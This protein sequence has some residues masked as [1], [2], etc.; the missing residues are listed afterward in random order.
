VEF[1]GAAAA[2]VSFSGEKDADA[3]HGRRAAQGYLVIIP[4]NLDVNHIVADI[5]F[6]EF[7][8]TL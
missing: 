8:I 6:V 5:S 1:E 4:H 3:T 2:T 7:D